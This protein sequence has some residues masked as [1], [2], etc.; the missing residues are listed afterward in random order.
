MS[1]INI[2]TRYL[3]NIMLCIV[4]YEKNFALRTISANLYGEQLRHLNTAIE[5][6]RPLKV[7]ACDVIYLLSEK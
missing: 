4:K 6:K 5:E 2:K 1:A 7:F 3:Y